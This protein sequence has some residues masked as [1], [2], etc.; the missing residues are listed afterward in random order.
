LSRCAVGPSAGRFT[1]SLPVWHPPHPRPGDLPGLVEA[2]PDLALA[3]FKKA[4]EGLR[5]ELREGAP[6]LVVRAQARHGR[7]YF[8]GA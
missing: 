4:A 8:G 1:F 6:W 2:R 7:P 5:V 3:F